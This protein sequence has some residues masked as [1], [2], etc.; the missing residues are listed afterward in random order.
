[1]FAF[2]QIS[3]RYINSKINRYM[4]HMLKFVDIVNAKAGSVMCKMFHELKI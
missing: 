4:L 3:Q 1:M 2:K